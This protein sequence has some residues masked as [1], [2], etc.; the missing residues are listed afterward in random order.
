VWLFL[1]ILNRVAS[2]L[3]TP[4]QRGD[5]VSVI[6]NVAMASTVNQFSYYASEPSKRS[7]GHIPAYNAEGDPQY[8]GHALEIYASQSIEVAYQLLATTQSMVQPNMTHAM[9]ANPHFATYR[10]DKATNA[11]WFQQNLTKKRPFW[12]RMGIH[13]LNFFRAIACFPPIPVRD[14][15]V[16]ISLTGFVDVVSHQED[17]IG[18][19]SAMSRVQ[20]GDNFKQ[21]FDSLR[22]G[23]PVVPVPAP[24]HQ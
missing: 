9:V 7:D 1:P 15:P 4:I 8:H 19:A 20:L 11:R 14:L 22:N 10:A 21:V 17:S 5:G 13:C 23:H 16:A 6:I 2:Q 3:V 12:T 18:L 24:F